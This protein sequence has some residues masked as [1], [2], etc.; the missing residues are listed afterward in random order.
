MERLTARNEFGDAYYKNCFIGHCIQK[1]RKECDFDQNYCDRLAEYEDLEISPEQVREMDSAYTKLSIEF[2]KYKKIEE[3]L[4]D[5][6]HGQLALEDIV[7]DLEKK[8][9]K[10]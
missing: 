9:A 4:N 2:A 1:N 8:N 3:K 7:A 10:N 6:S 5:I